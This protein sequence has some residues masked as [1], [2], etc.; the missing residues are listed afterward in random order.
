[1]TFAFDLISDLHIETWKDFDWT[2]QPTS[3]YC[4]VAGDVG[5]D[6]QTVIDT[7][8][9]LGKCYAGVFY[10][11]GNDEHRTYMEEL[12]SSYRELASEVNRIQNVV[13]LQDNVVIINGICLL[14]TNG[15]WTYDFDADADVEQNMLWYQDYIKVSRMA[16]NAAGATALNDVAYL[17]NSVK[18]LQTH[19]EVKKIVMITHTVPTPEITKHDPDLVGTHRYNYLGNKYMQSV[20]EHDTEGKISTWCFGHYHKTVD[21]YINGVHYINNCRGRGNTPWCQV[22]YYPRRI[23][24]EI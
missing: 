16:A 11:D 13:Y 12:D 8:T 6:R 23:E 20:F 1:M 3:P 14:A 5:Q 9:H 19:P 17:C 2:G 7:L 24:I 18:K 4:V 10:I 15:W 21:R 22:A